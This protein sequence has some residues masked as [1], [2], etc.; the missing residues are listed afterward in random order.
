MKSE[1]LEFC[2][3][4]WRSFGMSMDESAPRNEIIINNLVNWFNYLAATTFIG[5]TILNVIINYERFPNEV[6][7]FIALELFVGFALC[8]LYINASVNKYKIHKLMTDIDEF[9]NRRTNEFTRK[10]YTRTENIAY[11]LCKTFLPLNLS[12]YFFWYFSLLIFTTIYRVFFSREE[13]NYGKL[14]LM[15]YL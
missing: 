15:L 10:I 9:C 13:L 8:G 5:C 4:R 1:K 14:F 2:A 11:F 7:F 6:L 12:L 3:A